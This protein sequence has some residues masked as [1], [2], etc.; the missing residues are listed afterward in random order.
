[1]SRPL[2][3]SV[4]V[5]LLLGAAHVARAGCAGT[6]LSG[7]DPTGV[8]DNTAAIQAAIDAA[9][10]NGGGAVVLNPGRYLMN[11]TLAVKRGVVLCGATEGPFDVGVD[12]ALTTIAATFLITNT[13]APFITLDGSGA[14]VTDLFFHYPNQVLPTATTPNVYPFTIRVR[15]GA[16]TTKIERCTA[17]NAYQFLL[18]ESGRTIARDLYIGAFRYGIYVDHAADHVTLNNIIQTVFWDIGAYSSYPQPID[19]WVLNNGYAFVFLR[20]DSV[21]VHDV[22]VYHRY[23]AFYLADSPDVSQFPRNAYGSAT[24]IDIDTCRAGII[25]RSTNTPGF[26]FANIDIGCGTPVDP[27]VSGV[28]YVPGGTFPPAILVNGGSIRGTWERGPFE[29]FPPPAKLV[30]RHI[31][32]YDE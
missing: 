23:A 25:A 32:G 22:L 18:I 24:N 11:G 30:V 8:S 10:A 6:R 17:T 14:A 21:Q 2:V 15:P 16:P 29:S 19:A 26:K 9:Y 31:F 5:V 1:M 13:S 20:A 28:T 3:A 27:A 4:A 12:P 7:L